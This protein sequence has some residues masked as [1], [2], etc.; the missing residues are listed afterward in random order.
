MNKTD[1]SHLSYI[2]SASHQL[3]GWQIKYLFNSGFYKGGLNT[4]EIVDGQQ[5]ITTL[6]M[7]LIA[8]VSFHSKQFILMC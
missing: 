5:R 4:S 1:S 7:L 6:S 8:I 3:E 2:V